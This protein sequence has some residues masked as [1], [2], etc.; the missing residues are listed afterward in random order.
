MPPL[1]V[2][3]GPLRALHRFIGVGRVVGGVLLVCAIAGLTAW[4][5]PHP[6]APWA[7]QWA[8]AYVGS[9]RPDKA[10]AAYVR[11]ADV[12]L[13]MEVRRT[14]RLRASLVYATQLGRPDQARVQLEELVAVTGAPDSRAELLQ[15]IGELLLEEDQAPGAAARFEAAAKASPNH[16]LAGRRMLC[17]G[18]VLVAARRDRQAD[19]L[20]RQVGSEYPA[21]KGEADLGRA[22]LKLRKGNI[23]Q[24]L[25]L[26]E[27]A[28]THT[29]DADVAS[30]AR[31]GRTICLER[32]GDLDSALAELED[33]D[34]L[35][36]EI[37][38]ERAGAL[39]SRQWSPA[40]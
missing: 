24:A 2:H 29:Y 8:D 19:A 13:S 5:V 39:R 30:V 25:N 36:H 11:I 10:V 23:E 32:L 37:V 7:L 38:Q 18:N 31:L 21:L 27:G 9:G 17:A 22:Q 3:R 34:L 20:L 33:V 1:S 26:F 35:S 16:A 4:G 12:H 15:S 40:Q 6:A 28:L 14:A